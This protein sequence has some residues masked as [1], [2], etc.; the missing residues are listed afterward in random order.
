MLASHWPVDLGATARPGSGTKSAATARRPGADGT[1]TL[2]EAMLVLNGTEKAGGGASGLLLRTILGGRGG[3]KTAARLAMLHR[4]QHKALRVI[5][6]RSSHSF[7]VAALNLPWRECLTLSELSP[8]ANNAIGRVEA[9]LAQID[10]GEAQK[11]HP[12]FW[13]P[14]AVVGEV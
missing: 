9:M 10:K 3:G 2:Q 14:F 7:C 6:T 12:A 8:G 4:P 13:A 5:C 1:D 11:A